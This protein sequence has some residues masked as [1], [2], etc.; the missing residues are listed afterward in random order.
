ME[1]ACLDFK[2]YPNTVGKTLQDV[3]NEIL[4]PRLQSIRKQQPSKVLFARPENG[5]SSVEMDLGLWY[6]ASFFLG[7]EC[8]A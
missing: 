1:N 8:L 2:L 6:L 7:G 5:P 3:L 4:L